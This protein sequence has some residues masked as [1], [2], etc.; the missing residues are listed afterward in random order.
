MH[1]EGRDGWGGGEASGG[2]A[3][4]G[5][6][7]ACKTP[8]GMYRGDAARRFN[9]PANLVASAGQPPPSHIQHSYIYTPSLKVQVIFVLCVF[10]SDTPD[11][12]PLFD[13]R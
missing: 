2:E 1:V 12:R 13:I 6:R 4:G 8:V 5:G 7:L 10:I 9:L 11:I 3:S